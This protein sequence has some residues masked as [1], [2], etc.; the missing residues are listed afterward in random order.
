MDLINMS[1]GIIAVEYFDASLLE[2][3]RPDLASLAQISIKIPDDRVVV[4]LLDPGTCEVSGN[5]RAMSASLKFST[6]MLIVPHFRPAFLIQD[7][8]GSWFLI[9]SK[10]RPFPKIEFTRSFGSVPDKRPEFAYTI[11]HT[12]IVTP[13]EVFI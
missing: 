4:P 2:V 9:A 10:S 3:E 11:T 13:V 7:A 1:P 6:Q 8:N 12:A 5:E